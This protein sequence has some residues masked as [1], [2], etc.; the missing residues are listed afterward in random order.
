MHLELLKN[1][2]VGLTIFYIRV[3]TAKIDYIEIPDIIELK[4]RE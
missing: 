1:T 3:P 4:K 2:P